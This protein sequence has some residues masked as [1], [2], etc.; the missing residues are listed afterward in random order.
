M[1]QPPGRLQLPRVTARLLEVYGGT[2]ALL[3]FSP[4]AISLLKALFME[5]LMVESL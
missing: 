1:Q 4:L 3:G 5:R 2:R